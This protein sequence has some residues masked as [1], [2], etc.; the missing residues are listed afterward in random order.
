MPHPLAATIALAAFALLPFALVLRHLCSLPFTFFQSCLYFGSQLLTRL[1]WR[2]ELCNA[3]PVP[4]NQGAL[5]IC[6]H[7]SSID[8]FFIQAVM[9]R[10]SHWMV[11]KEYCESPLFGWFLK[12]AEVIP[13]NRGGVDTASTKAAIR[14]AAAGELVGIFP[15]GRINQTDAF[16]LPCRPGAILI[17]LRAKVPL[18]P[19]YLEGAPFRQEVWSPF[20]MPAH[21][22]LRFGPPID[23]NGLSESGGGDGDLGTIMLRCVRAIAQLAGHPDFEPKLAGRRWKPTPDGAVVTE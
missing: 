23:V 7:R 6:N 20:L 1:L 8:P 21:V 3:L 2:L 19:C 4:E 9:L 10:K 17:A 13:T 16:M 12:A 18:V 15:E 14:L 5:L 11:A 22:R